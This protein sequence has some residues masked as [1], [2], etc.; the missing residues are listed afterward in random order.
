MSEFSKTY[1]NPIKVEN[2]P[3]G[4][5]A[6]THRSIADPTVILHDGKWY[7]FPS[8]SMAY[9][10]E[11]FVTW[12]HAQISPS[13]LGYA[14]TVAKHRGFFY[15]YAR[16]GEL[17]RAKEPLGPYENLGKIKSDDEIAAIYMNVDPMIFEDDDQRAYIYFSVH[18]RDKNG[19]LDMSVW[20]IELDTNDLTRTVG[21]AKRLIS[22][23]PDHAW[24][25]YGPRNQDTTLGYIEGV[26]MVKVGGRYYLTY[27]ACGTRFKNY[28]MGAYYSDTGPLSDFVYQKKNPIS[29]N[30]C[31][32]V[33]GGGHGSVTMGP[34]GK[35]WAFYTVPVGYA[36]PFE[37]RVG[38]DPV[39]IDENGEIS[40]LPNTDTPRWAPG[41][42][43]DP[44]EKG[45]TGLLPLS[46]TMPA[47]AT[48]FAA[49]RDPIYA[50]DESMLSFW[51]PKP[52]DEEKALTVDLMTSYSVSAAR[53][54]W[55]EVGTTGAPE[56]VH[57]A[58]RYKVELSA[59]KQSWTTVIDKSENTH[60]FIVDYEAFDTRVARY[61]RLTV[62][63]SPNG[64][65][66]GVIS[67][68]VFGRK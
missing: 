3:F 36:H 49:G 34:D 4:Y 60:D 53:I 43:E 29:G 8:Y 32:L 25:C 5:E 54:I 59:D 57:G 2:C 28:R 66:P 64:V 45:D 65:E 35:L 30:T 7:M 31:G 21:K 22:F 20:G 61:A 10:S 48:S 14:P 9:V 11:D 37:R 51:Q 52:D 38:M 12:R 18:K 47:A 19:T 26:W 67:F 58:F 15:L 46:F 40:V 41:V 24:E 6:P 33:T 50:F 55:R 63:G 62:C 23:D 13:D 68:T 44:Y 27:S 39:T 1:C 16:S 17:Y 42:K 56:A